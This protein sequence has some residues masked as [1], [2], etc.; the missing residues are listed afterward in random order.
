VTTPQLPDAPHGGR[1]AVVYTAL[2]LALFVGCFVVVYLV[3]LRGFVA[4]VVAL[5]VSGLLSLFVL[6]RLR[7]AMSIGV[8]RR[9]SRL[10][11]RAEARTAAEDAYVD[12]LHE[13]EERI[14]R[15]DR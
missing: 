2:R 11:A 6:A 1:A 8:D 12:A 10:R 7:T 14:T 13:G 5:V 4:L 3:G 9:I 15:S